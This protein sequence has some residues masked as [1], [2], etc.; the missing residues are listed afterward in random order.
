MLGLPQLPRTLD[1]ALRDIEHERQHVRLSAL[2]DLVR[3]AA[4]PARP[5]AVAALGRALLRDASAE[6][7]TEAA[8]G[9]ADAQASE[10]RAELLAALDDTHVRVRQMAIV[11]LGEIAEPGD[12]EV[13][14]AVRGL[15]VHEEAAL[16]FQ[17][18]IAF[19]RL[20]AAEAGS[21]LVRATTDSDVEV[22]SMAFRLAERRFLDGDP[23]PEL[24]ESARRVALGAPTAAST[25]AALFLAAQGD[26]S[27]AGVL[28]GALARK[29]PVSSEADLQAV[30]EA[31]V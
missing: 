22:S 29:V 3:L 7:R 10:A 20:A 18:L 23:P 9:L 16:R 2:R 12:R 17:A 5:R 11:A 6:L 26:R 1:A 15:L 27:G 13:L 21:V 14:E 4:G 31:V 25:S 30:T 8:V 28:V 24:V 19:E